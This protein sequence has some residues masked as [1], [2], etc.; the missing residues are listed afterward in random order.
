MTH[1]L[2]A[3]PPH[4]HTHTYAAQGGTKLKNAVAGWPENREWKV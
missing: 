3:A 4:T 2:T 1:T